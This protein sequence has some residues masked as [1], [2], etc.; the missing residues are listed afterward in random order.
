LTDL[1]K[2]SVDLPSMKDQREIVQHIRS[3]HLRESALANEAGRSHNLLSRLDQA[4][5]AKTFRGELVPQSGA[6]QNVSEEVAAG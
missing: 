3:A 1:R 4:T 2:P 6:M 5:L